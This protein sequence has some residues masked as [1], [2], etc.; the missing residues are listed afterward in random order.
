M[1]RYSKEKKEHALSLMSAPHNLVVAEVARRTGVTEPTLYAWRNQ[2]RG[3]GRAVPGDGS[4]PED[5]KPEDK[6]AVVVETV[7]IHPPVLTAPSSR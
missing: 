6:F 4:N 2:A 3:A 7:R 5:W 1:P